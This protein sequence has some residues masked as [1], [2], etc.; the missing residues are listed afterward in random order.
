MAS[1]SRR[2]SVYGVLAG[3]WIAVVG[4]L[5]ATAVF[6]DIHEAEKR[7]TR[8]AA[9]I[10]GDLVSE[11]RRNLDTARGF[12]ALFKGRGGI[13]RE[14]AAA[15]ARDVLADGR[16][17][18]LALARESRIMPTGATARTQRALAGAAP[19][20][21]LVFAEPDRLDLRRLFRAG[22][23]PSLRQVLQRARQTKGVVAGA[24]IEVR[25]RHRLYPLME[26]VE[27]AGSEAFAV[28][29][30]KLPRLNLPEEESERL[31]VTVFEA[32]GSADPLILNEG[33]P[34]GAIGSPMFPRLRFRAPLGGPE[35]GRIVKIE[36]QLGWERLD[37]GRLAAILVL[38][39]LVLVL[40]SHLAR[41]YR[42]HEEHTA[43]EGNRLFRMAN[44]DALTG[45][46]NRQMFGNRLE[47]ALAVAHRTGQRHAL[48]YLDLDG[49]KEINDCYG[50]LAGD[51][52][53]RRAACLFKSCVREADLVARI[54]GDEFAIL[55]LDVGGRPGVDRVVRQI[56]Q[57]FRHPSPCLE[58]RDLIPPRLGT[59][60]GVAVYPDDGT[61]PA[62]LLEA[63]DRSM[64][65]DKTAGKSRPRRESY[66][67]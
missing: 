30:C 59:S 4:A 55:L 9:L 41:I 14:I 23:P 53:L 25:Q 11:V 19:E 7:F 40:F 26:R 43:A 37:R 31:T 20:F 66:A 52:A 48:L 17:E 22:F 47:Q 45:L 21:E 39:F 62:E 13:D 5:L 46:A 60:I 38:A 2:L 6:L 57:A 49:F 18:F 12:A 29:F 61:T 35:T 56:K 10:Y 36:E 1:L 15:F 32:S 67:G 54:G 63:A 42:R 58:S 3:A 65:Q 24:P 51:R 64:Y 27:A 16:I 44:F 50:H 28:V 8:N 33:R 34:A